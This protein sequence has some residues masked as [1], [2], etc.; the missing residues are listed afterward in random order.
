MGQGLTGYP[1]WGCLG[2]AW[3]SRLQRR[4]P[5]CPR[6]DG[7]RYYLAGGQ[8][9][10]RFRQIGVL[11]YDP[12]PGVADAIATGGQHTPRPECLRTTWRALAEEPVISRR[13]SL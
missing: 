2:F 1:Y 3:P 9:F 7:H 12:G 5:T 6:A 4:R 10:R 8:D 13:L 11:R